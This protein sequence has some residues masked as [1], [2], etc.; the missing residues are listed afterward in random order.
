MSWLRISSADEVPKEN[1]EKLQKMQ[2]KAWGFH[3]CLKTLIESIPSGTDIKEVRLQDWPSRS[4]P[5]KSGLTTL[6]GDSAHPMTMYRGEAFNHGVTD[7]AVLVRQI[8]E[9]ERGNLRLADAMERYGA[10]VVARTHGAVLLSRQACLDAHDYHELHSDSPLVSKRSRVL[11]P[12]INI[13]V[14]ATDGCCSASTP[15]SKLQQSIEAQKV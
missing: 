6:A 9:V 11:V 7:A 4:W 14:R 5:T 12:A 10:G 1:T 3:P 15:Q 13:S 8:I 2:N